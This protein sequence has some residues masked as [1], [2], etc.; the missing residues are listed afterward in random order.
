MT[1]TFFEAYCFTTSVTWGFVR[2]PLL[3][4]R[5]LQLVDELP[6]LE[7]AHSVTRSRYGKSIEQPAER[8]TPSEIFLAHDVDLERCLGRASCSASRVGVTRRRR[9]SGAPN[10]DCENPR[11]A[12]HYA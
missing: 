10:D 7:P 4:E 5:G 3:L 11:E 12:M 8:D 2:I 6:G 9:P 1:L